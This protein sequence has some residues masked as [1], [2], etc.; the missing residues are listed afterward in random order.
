MP[1]RRAIPARSAEIAARPGR[2]ENTVAGVN[3]A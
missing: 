2:G 1:I 3:F